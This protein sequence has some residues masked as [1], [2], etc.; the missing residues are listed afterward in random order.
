MKKVL[1]VLLSV[2]M[3]TSVCTA[4][5]LKLSNNIR[6]GHS[7]IEYL[8]GDC[9]EVFVVFFY[10]NEIVKVEFLDKI[11]V[12]ETKVVNVPVKADKFKLMYR[13]LPKE[14]EYYNTEVNQLL[15]MKGCI[16]ID[17]R[18]EN[19]FEITE[20]MKFTNALSE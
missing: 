11:K 20:K 14:S 8:D 6:A 10:K 4:Q 7:T 17:S 3:L 5:T 19:R 13:F 16:P 9:N 2:I 15:I 18:K 12:G 1:L